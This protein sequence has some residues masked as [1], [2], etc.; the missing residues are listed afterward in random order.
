M[1]FYGVVARRGCT[2]PASEVIGVRIPSAPPFMLAYEGDRFP[3]LA[4]TAYLSSV[5][6]RPAGLKKEYADTLVGVNPTAPS[7]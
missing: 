4:L 5:D 2:R 7:F 6:Y 3:Q 1:P